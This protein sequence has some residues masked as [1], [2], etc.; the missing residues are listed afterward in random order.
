MKALFPSRRR[1]LMGLSL[2]T[3]LTATCSFDTNQLRAWPDGAVE[4]PA[5]PD[6]GASEGGGATTG[7]PDAPATTGGSGGTAASS[8][9]AAVGTGGRGGTDASPP[10]A[11]SARGGSGGTT[12]SPVDA[13]IARGGSG[14]A[15]T[16]PDAPAATG[17]S[18]GYAGVGGTGGAGRSGGQTAAGGAGGAGT[19]GGTVGTDAGVGGSGG[20]GSGGTAGR[21]GSGGGA[22]G[23]S[24]AGGTTSTASTPPP[25]NALG[26]YVTG[27][28][29]GAS[30]QISLSLRIDNRTSQSV[31]MSTVTL[32]YWYQDEGLG[33]T[34]ALSL[35]Y[36]GIGYSNQ[37]TVTLS[38][39]VA[40]SP[41]VAG[42][43][44]YL[45]LSFIGTL[46]AQGDKASNDQFNIRVGVHTG[47]YQ[48]AVDVTNDYSY[49]AGALGY[50]DK[51]TLHDKS[52]NVIWGTT[53]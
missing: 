43:D 53:P 10:D 11:A 20:G 21:A 34:L 1:G 3:A 41:A 23:I 35:L 39:V 45:E 18:G 52:G 51:I 38:K 6:V 8:P 16:P 25:T 30:G 27:K 26:V 50:S 9:D 32:R 42:A 31:D 28:T 47:N 12:A 33:T 48:G 4:L 2:I 36:V 13:A 5:P 17:G 22:G 37:G 19:V 24:S 49:N 15:T 14:G 40:V 29:A 7:P 44:H 46:A